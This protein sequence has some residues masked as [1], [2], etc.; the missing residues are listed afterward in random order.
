M[1]AQVLFTVVYALVLATWLIRHVLIG[2]YARR[3]LY[4]PKDSPQDLP[5]PAPLVSVLIPARDEE[6]NIERCVRSILDQTYPNLEVLVVDDRSADRTAAIVEGIAANDPRVRLIRLTALPEG[7][8]GKC[9]GLWTAA[10]QAR[11]EY[12]LFVDADT[13][14]TPENLAI[15]MH[16]MTERQVDMLSLVP[17]MRNETFWEHVVQPLAGICLMV[18][19]PFHRVNDPQHRSSFGNGQYI[20]IRRTAYDAIGGHREVR[21]ELV[22]DIHLAR[23][24]KRHGMCL[25]VA[26]APDIS[27]TRMYTSLRRIVRGWGRIYFA[28]LDK[29][30]VRLSVSMLM[31]L[32]FSVSAYVMFGLSL[33]WLATGA[34]DAFTWTVLGMSVGHLAIKFTV[35]WRLYGIVRN[36]RWYLP[37]YGLAALAVLCAQASAIRNRLGRHVMWRGTAYPKRTDGAPG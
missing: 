5:D 22:E 34:R 7:W 24:I 32:V 20:L 16:L 10:Q 3:Q 21:A 4:L 14:Q 13:L 33:V 36:N 28:A 25:L 2:V 15:C 9:N 35:M 29:S 17:R 19:Y 26:I 6:E 37:L 23:A 11:G 30:L 27:S 18:W 1:T 8:T 12:L 31:L